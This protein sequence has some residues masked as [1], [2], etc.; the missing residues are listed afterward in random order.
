MM[1]LQ[2]SFDLQQQEMLK[3]KE[4][5]DEERTEWRAK[6]D[7]QIV[8]IEVIP[9]NIPASFRSVDNCVNFFLATEPL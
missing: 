2:N 3:L 7:E 5:Q 8:S 1:E 6:H 4:R 9:Y